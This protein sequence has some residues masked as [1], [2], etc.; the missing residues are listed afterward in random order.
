MTRTRQA[1]KNDPQRTMNEY[2][3]GSSLDEAELLGML[4]QYAVLQ[5]DYSDR[6]EEMA[7]AQENR[8]DQKGKV[9]AC[10]RELLELLPDADL[11][12]AT[13]RAG[14]FIIAVTESDGGPVAFER[15]PRRRVRIIL[16][17]GN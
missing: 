1:I 14:E 17:K 10:I 16:P 4:R 7:R 3:N 13:Y 5:E 8:D 12:I 6:R 15:K 2:L 11:P 9:I